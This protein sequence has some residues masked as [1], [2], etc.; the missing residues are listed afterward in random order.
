MSNN[1]FSLLNYVGHKSK[2]L[3][4][5]IPQ[6]PKKIE[7]TFWDIF[8]GSSVVGLSTNFQT[9]KFVD[10]NKY[11]TTLYSSLTNPNFRNDL[12]A[13]LTNYNLTNSSRTPRSSYLNDPNI[14]TCMWHGKQI[15]NLHLDKLN[16]KGYRKLLQDVNNG[17]FTTDYQNSIAYMILTLYGRNSNVVLNKN[18]KLNGDVGPLDFSKKA[19]KKLEEHVVTIKNRNCTWICDTYKNITPQENDF[20]YLDP[21]Y[22]A[23]A[24]KYGGWDENDEKNL[25]EWIDQL[26]CNWALSNVLNSGTDQNNILIEWSKKYKV[27]NL[28]KNYRKWA[29]AGN[30]TAKKSIKNNTEVLITNYMALSSNW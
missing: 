14:G 26:K 17:I 30:S 27:I 11:I 25:L 22:L 10:S 23:S 20:V 12:E 15:P 5:I 28:N 3:D 4:Q 24:Y 18:G 29:S 9:I 8:C 2:L 1:I 13:L 16:Q 19:A 21:P 6:F 7:G